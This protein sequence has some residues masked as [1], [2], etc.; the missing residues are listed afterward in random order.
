MAAP[1]ANEKRD[2][3][4]GHALFAGLSKADLDSLLARARV[5]HYPAGRKIFEKG[6]PGRSMM[7]IIRGSV[8]ISASSA[9]GRELVLAILQPGE[10]FGEIALLDGQRRT[11]D[12]TA[13]TDCELLVL[14]H[15]EFVPFLERRPDVSLQLLRVF[16]HR[17][18]DTNEH[19]EHAVFEHINRRLART[20]LHLASNTPRTGKAD[21]PGCPIRVSQQE[22]ADMVGATRESVNKKLRGW[23]SA[24]LVRLG[25]RSIVIT[26]IAGIRALT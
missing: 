7:A 13:V 12:A 17:L 20:L 2:L 15:R 18:R 1:T 24:G 16:C 11:A 8:R 21:D 4:D 23:Q 10:I 22:L 14:D 25:S 6:A 5:E 3:V 9:V 19:V 26:D